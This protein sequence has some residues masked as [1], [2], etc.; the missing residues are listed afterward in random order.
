M[1]L[2]ITAQDVESTEQDVE[3]KDNPV[4]L[5]AFSYWRF[6]NKITHLK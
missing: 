5:M 4:T 1:L 3:T 2:C 6:S